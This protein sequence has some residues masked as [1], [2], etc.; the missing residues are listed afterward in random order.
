MGADTTPRSGKPFTEDAPA[1]P[2]GP[3]QPA[4]NLSQYQQPQTGQFPNSFV[5]L[6]AY[7]SPTMSAYNPS[8]ASPGGYSQ[9]QSNLDAMLRSAYYGPQSLGP[10]APASTAAAPAASGYAP[11]TAASAPGGTQPMSGGLS[12]GTSG[13]MQGPIGQS[14]QPGLA[15]QGLPMQQQDDRFRNLRGYLA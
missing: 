10:S 2:P 11:S 9:G 15:Q 13:G 4:T 1:L 12:G 7:L 3:Q 6:Q 14:P 5:N 8:T